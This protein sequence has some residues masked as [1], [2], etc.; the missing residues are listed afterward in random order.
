[1]SPEKMRIFEI[2]DSSKFWLFTNLTVQNNLGLRAVR[3][4]VRHPIWFGL[5]FGPLTVDDRERLVLAELSV[6]SS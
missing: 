6:G 5:F 1:M 4:F 2:H 3:K